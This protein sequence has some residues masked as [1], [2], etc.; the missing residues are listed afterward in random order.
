MSKTFPAVLAAALLSQSLTPPASAAEEKSDTTFLPSASSPLVAV[1]FLFQVGS[2][3][4][5]RGK[6][7]LAALTAAMVA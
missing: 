4:D 2:Q 7:G 6:E 1:R 3:D 5:P